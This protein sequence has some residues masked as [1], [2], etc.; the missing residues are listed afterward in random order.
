MLFKKALTSDSLFIERRRM[1]APLRKIVTMIYSHLA[2]EQISIK[3]VLRWRRT[4]HLSFSYCLFFF[5]EAHCFFGCK[6]Q[7]IFFLATYEPVPAGI[8]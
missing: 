6:E 7:F 8:G 4:L 5:I 2:G 3:K 1:T